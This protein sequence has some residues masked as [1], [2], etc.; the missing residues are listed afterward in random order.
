MGSR[1]AVGA[2]GGRGTSGRR[3]GL[4]GQRKEKNP[5]AIGGN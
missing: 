1:P 2:G 4:P 5:A 3:A